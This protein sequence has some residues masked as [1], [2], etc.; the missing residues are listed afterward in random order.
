MEVLGGSALDKPGAI[1]ENSCDMDA[2]GPLNIG[3]LC[4]PGNLTMAPMAGY[5]QRGQRVLARCY[6]ASLAWTEM[7]S[8]YEILRPG[9]KTRR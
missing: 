4:L 7:I 6:G 5:T 8:D 3:S 2:I 9:K 1:H